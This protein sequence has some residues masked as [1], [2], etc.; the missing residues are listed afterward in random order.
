MKNVTH[1]TFLGMLAYKIVYGTNPLLPKQQMTKILTVKDGIEYSLDFD[2]HDPHLPVIQRMIES[3]QII[4]SLPSSSAGW[5]QTT[6]DLSFII[7]VSQR[8]KKQQQSM[9][10]NNKTIKP[11]SKLV[12][13]QIEKVEIL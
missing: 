2:A 11:F 7:L 6:Q 9:W 1:V 3:F 12:I 10:Y 4:S 5:K 13:T 8:H